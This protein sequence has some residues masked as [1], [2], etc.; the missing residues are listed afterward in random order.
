VKI[1]IINVVIGQAKNIIA[2]PIIAYI[3]IDFDFFTL[4][5]SQAA[6]RILNQA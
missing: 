3:I 5:S 4:S 1:P 2:S 6:V